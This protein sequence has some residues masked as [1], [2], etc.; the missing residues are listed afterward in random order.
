MKIVFL[1]IKTLGYEIDVTGLHKFGEVLVYDHVIDDEVC[2]VISDADIVITNQNKLN[3]SN[4][5]NAEKLKLICAAATGYDNI[6]TVY[7]TKHNIAVAN[8]PGYAAGSVAQH[9]FSMLF[10]LISH[11]RYYD[12]Y[13]KS[14][15][16]SK[17]EDTIHTG[18]DFIELEGKTWGIIGLGEIGKKVASYAECFGCNVI[19][20]ST[21][22]RNQHD[23]YKS[24]ELEEL[25]KTSDI[26][27]IHAPMNSRTKHLIGIEQIKQMKKTAYLLNLGRG[28]IIKESDLSEAISNNLIAGAG[29]DVFEIE[30]LPVESP[31]LKLKNGDNLFLTPHIGYGSVEARNRLMMAVCKNIEAFLSGA[32]CNRL[33]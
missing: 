14:G 5:H 16:F 11:S 30:P 9:T 19:Y 10:Y 21:S 15:E 33:V 3:E 31:L 6:D 7:C 8:V 32:L 27:S 24:V 20:Y 4:L 28:G 12:D 1:D 13:V 22:G 29:L 26:I 23:H 18:K 2:N 25:L 17:A